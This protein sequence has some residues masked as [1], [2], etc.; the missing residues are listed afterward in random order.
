MLL[1]P[2][3]YAMGSHVQERQWISPKILWRSSAPGHDLLAFFVPN[4]MNPWLGA[5]FRE[6]L[7][8]LPNG[9]VENV[10]AIPWVL[11]TVIV[12]ALASGRKLPR[13]WLVFTA[14]VA[15]LAMGPF[16]HV[17][18]VNTFV[19]TP[20]TL[21]RFIPVIGAARMPT[22]FGVLVLLGASMLLAFALRDLRTRWRRP[23]L[24][25]ACVG[26]LLLIE[27]SPAPRPVHSAA[28]PSVYRIIAADPRPIRVLNLPFG[29]SDGLSSYGSTTPAWQFFQTV[30]EKPLLGG[31][32]SRLPRSRIEYYERRHVTGV[33]LHL[34]ARRPVSADRF[35][36]A[37]ARAREIR[38]ELNVGYVVIDVGRASEELVAFAHAAFDLVPI[39]TDGPFH[40]FR[41]PL[42]PPVGS[43]GDAKTL[44]RH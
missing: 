43:A 27:L 29:L 13:Y 7:A 31:A 19:P 42:T 28:V 18:G 33:L 20:W 23:A 9:F 38:D 15:L 3:L 5:P 12:V 26:G 16:V 11:L 22:R 10:A 41:T 6:T 34:S 30:H 40:L 17:G 39:A 2:V 4:P 44:L 14:T 1:S 25:T 36:S 32:L 21:L 24:T 35:A 8:R 37:V